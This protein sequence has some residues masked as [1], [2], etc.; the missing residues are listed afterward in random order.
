MGGP[1]DSPAAALAAAD[2]DGSVTDGGAGTA[3]IPCV[4][5][6]PVGGGGGR[7]TGAPPMPGVGG[8][9]DGIEVVRRAP[10]G[11]AGGRATGAA[12]AGAGGYVAGAGARPPAR[13]SGGGLSWR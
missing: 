4:E 7:V 12:A 5:R 3:G 13:S 1:K 8:G 2:I 6:R 9:T 10:G 11:T